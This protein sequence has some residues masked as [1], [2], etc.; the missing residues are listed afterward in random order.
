MKKILLSAIVIISF[1]SYS[2]YVRMK[3]EIKPFVITPHTIKKNNRIFLTPRIGIKQKPTLQ[4]IQPTAIESATSPSP[5][6]SHYKDGTYVGSVANAIYG[7]IQVKII[8][9][10]GKISNIQFL[11]YPNDQG[12]STAINQQNDPT[13]AQEAIQVQS[14]QV[15]IISGATQTS[16]AFIQSLQSALSKANS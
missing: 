15:D 13:L 14:A 8:I 16:Q 4:V 7:N 11:Q 2:V 3:E 9:V 5:S 12:T 1:I 10:N 6:N